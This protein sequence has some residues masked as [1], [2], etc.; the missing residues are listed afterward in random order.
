MEMS[1]NST[2]C[3]ET[4]QMS[5]VETEQMSAVETGQ[6]YARIPLQ[7]ARRQR[8]LAQGQVITAV[9]TAQQG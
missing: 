4:G 6:L 2:L 1:E 7:G 5:S 8:K 3:V 9:I